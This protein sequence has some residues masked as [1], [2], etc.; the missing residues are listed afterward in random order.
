MCK[1]EEMVKC[2]CRKEID[3][4]ELLDT[5][6]IGIKTAFGSC[7]LIWIV[8]GKTYIETISEKTAKA[9]IHSGMDTEG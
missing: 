2:E 9:L 8:N 5:L 6:H 1:C 4:N 7:K 3:L